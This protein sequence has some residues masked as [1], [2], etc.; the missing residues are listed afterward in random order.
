MHKKEHQRGKLQAAAGT[1]KAQKTGSE[2][3]DDS[4]E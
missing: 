2:Q 3:L 4:I 1:I